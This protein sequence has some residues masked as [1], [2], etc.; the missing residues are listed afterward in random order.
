MG[1]DV[2]ICADGPDGC[3]PSTCFDTGHVGYDLNGETCDVTLAKRVAPSPQ[4]RELYPGRLYG[5]RRYADAGKYE[6]VLDISILAQ[7]GTWSFGLQ[8]GDTIWRS[9]HDEPDLLP[10]LKGL[11]AMTRREV[12]GILRGLGVLGPAGAKKTHTLYRFFDDDGALLYIGVT[13]SPPNRFRAHRADKEWWGMVKTVKMEQFPSRSALMAGEAAAIK[14][15][16]PRYNIVHNISPSSTTEAS[17]E[18]ARS[19]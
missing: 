15:E 10:F 6:L 2:H 5:V 12:R 9:C 8:E 13:N 16:R 19:A 17:Q 3:A 4:M 7:Q 1:T 18:C 14:A 11:P